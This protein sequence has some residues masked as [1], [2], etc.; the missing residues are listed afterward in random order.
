MK[1][2]LSGETFALLK[3]R[4]LFNAL[5]LRSS[6]QLSQVS[7]TF[8]RAQAPFLMP[9]S[10]RVA[11]VRAERNPYGF[12][13]CHTRYFKAVFM[14]LTCI[15]STLNAHLLFREGLPRTPA[16]LFARSEPYNLCLHS[17]GLS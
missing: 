6:S 13:G 1:K 10:F 2:S 4:L 11:T 15:T 7:M 14:A 16:S 8:W 9:C 3:R 17:V 12:P 5:Q